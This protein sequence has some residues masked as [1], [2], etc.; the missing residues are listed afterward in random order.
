MN[1]NGAK[2]AHMKSEVKTK[3]SI[4][5]KPIFFDFTGR[6]LATADYLTRTYI[7]HWEICTFSRVTGS[8]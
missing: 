3:L 1:R 2:I 7:G 6:P 5:V 4:T 8:T